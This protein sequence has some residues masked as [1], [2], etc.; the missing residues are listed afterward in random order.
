MIYATIQEVSSQRATVKRRNTVA[1]ID[2]NQ[3]VNMMNSSLSALKRDDI[4]GTTAHNK[5]CLNG[6]LPESLQGLMFH[7]D[8]LH[9]L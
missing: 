6:S 5:I 7:S 4:L 3:Y 9:I 1:I 2:K 8:P